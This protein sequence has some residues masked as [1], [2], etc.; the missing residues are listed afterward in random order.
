[1]KNGSAVDAAVA[2]L[3]CAGAVNIHS[4]GIGGGGFMVVYKRA[5]KSAEVLDYRETAP[6]KSSERMYL[7]NGTSSVLGKLRTF[8][9]S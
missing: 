9:V 1:M 7:R 6:M 4:T 5:N 8:K 2:S 3:F